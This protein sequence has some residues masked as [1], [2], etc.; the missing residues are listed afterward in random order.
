MFKIFNFIFEAFFKILA[1]DLEEV[2][3]F[4]NIRFWLLANNDFI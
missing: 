2:N 1:K 4:N 3:I